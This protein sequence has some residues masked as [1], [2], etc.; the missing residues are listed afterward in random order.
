MRRVGVTP[1]SAP[2]PGPEAGALLWLLPCR[3][4][5]RRCTPPPRRQNGRTPSSGKPNVGAPPPWAASSGTG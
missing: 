1:R 4:I 2:R 3:S 5:A